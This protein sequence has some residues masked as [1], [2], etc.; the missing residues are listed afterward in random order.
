[1]IH[2]FHILGNAD[3]LDERNDTILIHNPLEL[4]N[5]HVSEV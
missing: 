2:E 3:E 4:I 5:E 1:M